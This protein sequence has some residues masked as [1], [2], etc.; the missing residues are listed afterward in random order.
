MAGL[1]DPLTNKL[2]DK[3]FAEMG[4]VANI[5]FCSK[6]WG[7]ELKDILLLLKPTIDEISKRIPESD[8]S[9][10]R[11]KQFKGFQ[12]D[13]QDGLRLVENLEKIRS[14]DIFRKYRYGKKIRKFQGKLSDF[15]SR[16]PLKIALDVQKLDADCRN[17]Y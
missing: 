4:R 7:R 8:L 14:F 11:G 16:V 2:L 1:I 9:P 10:D 13:L 15:L 17:N 12:A 3:A 5:I 6:T